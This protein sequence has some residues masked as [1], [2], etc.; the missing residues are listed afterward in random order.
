MTGL[1][2][3][4]PIGAVRAAAGRGF[5]AQSFF[6]GFGITLANVSLFICS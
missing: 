3:Q 4:P 6:T 2:I 1:L 5:L